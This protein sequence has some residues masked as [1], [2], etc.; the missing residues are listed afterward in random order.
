MKK[1]ILEAIQT[2]NNQETKLKNLKE[3]RN[4]YDDAIGHYEA[5]LPELIKFIGKKYS[6]GKVNAKSYLRALR[7]SY[8][9]FECVPIMH[10]SLKEYVDPR[11]ATND[12]IS[13]IDDGFISW[14]E[15]AMACLNYMSDD[16]VKDMC[17]INDFNIA[18]DEDLNEARQKVERDV[19]KIPGSVAW[20]LNKYKSEFEN[21]NFHAMRKKVLEIL[22]SDEIKDKKA[23]KEAIKYLSIGSQS[24]FMSTLWTYMS[25]DK[26][27]A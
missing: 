16:D 1:S 19:T 4:E 25:G 14:E 8:D 24:S 5:D 23:A 20:V 27:I 26:V 13:A 21:L 18:D 12:L 10:E 11:R 9:Q 2:L 15:V 22:H 7:N 3:N 17:R 6:E